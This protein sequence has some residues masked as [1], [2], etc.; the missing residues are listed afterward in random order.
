MRHRQRHQKFFIYPPIL[1]VVP[2]GT[3]RG[4]GHMLFPR[5]TRI[6]FSSLSVQMTP[7]WDGCGNLPGT[8]GSSN[9]II[10]MWTVGSSCSFFMRA[11]M[12]RAGR[13]LCPVPTCCCLSCDAFQFLVL[14]RKGP[15]ARAAVLLSNWVQYEVI[16]LGQA[17]PRLPPL[18]HPNIRP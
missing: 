6:L 7:L 2:E 3:S 13:V 9:L 12:V 1:A 10:P 5:E 14:T 17:P 8:S 15:G 11:E 4:P 18:I 16:F